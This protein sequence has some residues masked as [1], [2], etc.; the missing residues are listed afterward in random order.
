MARATAGGQAA[1]ALIRLSGPLSK[2]IVVRAL[3]ISADLL[4]PRRPHLGTFHDVRDEA[5]DQVLV[6]WFPE[7]HSYTGE[8][9]VEISCHGSPFICRSIV[10]ACLARGARTAEPGEFTRRA[11]LRGKL[12]LVQAEAVRDLVASQ[13]EYQASLA[14]QQ[15][16]GRLGREL[17]PIRENLIDILAQLE[18][19]LEF[20]E[21]DVDPES[22]EKLVGGIEQVDEGL[23]RLSRRYATARAI[24]EGAMV[25]LAGR[26]NAGKS[27]VFNALVN[28]ERAIVTEIPGTTRD[29]LREWLDVGGL[30]VCLVDTAGIGR[31]GDLLVEEGM[32]RSKRHIEEADLVLFVVDSVAGF[33]TEDELLLETISTKPFVVAMNKTDLVSAPAVPAGVRERARDVLEISA[34]TGVNLEKLADVVQRSVLGAEGFEKEPALITNLRQLGCI[35]EARGSL[36]A[37]RAALQE[38]LSEEFICYDLRRALEA[39]GELTGETTT[40]DILGRIFST[41]CIGK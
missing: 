31:G 36:A 37:G 21:E 17:R 30:A 33:G 7:P 39:L 29:A 22:R 11:F 23:Q 13:T 35:E 28:D 4:E 12:D 2:P 40:E 19:R 14:R 26:P 8:E 15:L 32:K 20:V 10:A 27:S 34:K 5:L 9:V 41:F 24:R 3:G 16:R 18:T 25:V 1:I 6:T 38:G